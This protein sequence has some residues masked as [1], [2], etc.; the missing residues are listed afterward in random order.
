M[1]KNLLKQGDVTLK[2]TFALLWKWRKYLRFPSP[3]HIAFIVLVLSA[4]SL[5]AQA[6]QTVVVI[7]PSVAKPTLTQVELRQIFTGHL[8]YWEDGNKIHVFVLEDNDPLHKAFCRETLKMFPYQLSRLWNQLTYS[9][10]GVTP[11]RV[12]SKEELIERLEKTP[13]AIGYMPSGV[14]SKARMVKVVSQ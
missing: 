11:T 6:D 8:Q 14:V 2:T 12:S 5:N 9:G 13:G 7:N 3:K 4:W 10:Q 1:I